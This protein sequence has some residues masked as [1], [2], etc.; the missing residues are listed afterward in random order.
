M[1]LVFK[2]VVFLDGLQVLYLQYF[3]VDLL[4]LDLWEK[5]VLFGFL[6]GVNLEFVDLVQMLIVGAS[7]QLDFVVFEGQFLV[8]EFSQVLFALE[9]LLDV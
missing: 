5:L 7:Q 9:F 8:V 2:R 4:L 3:Q 6:Y 1:V